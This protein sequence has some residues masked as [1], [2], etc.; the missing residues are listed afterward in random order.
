MAENTNITLENVFDIDIPKLALDSRFGSLV[1]ENAS[2]KFSQAQAWLKE[3]HDLE[4]KELL[5]ESDI[6]QVTNLTSR[7]VEHLEWIRNFDIGVVANPKQ[8][9]DGF[10]N[11]I[12]SF[13][14]DVYSQILMRILP[15]LREERRRKNP[16][17]EQLDEEVKKVVQ[18][19]SE[20]E[21]E[22]KSVREE[23]QKIRITNK[24]VGSA[25]GERATARL[26]AH[27]DNEVVR[28]ENISRKW[29]IAVILG[30][31]VIVGVLVW[32]GVI[33]T[34]YVNRILALPDIVSTN[35]LWSVI[36]SKLVILAAL[37]YGL[38]FIIKNYNVNSHLSAIN[39]HRAAVARTLEDFIAV[40]LQQEN[41]RISEILQNASEAMF[42]NM[43]IGYVSKTEKETGN[44]VL[45]VV[46][47]LIGI[48]NNG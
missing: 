40:E 11:R 10:N 22:L 12:D 25:R 8:E 26:A 24:E 3:T 32:L 41:P 36:I 33:T 23:T 28:Y 39:R 45:Q 47:D 17:Q 13:Y 6:Q 9:H 21:K 42:K 27:F 1:F 35:G 5:L 14:N 16:D 30:Y 18:I 31:T 46:N 7:L 38:S 37:W 2:K 19:R 34:S 44:P 20:L 29:F 15:F 4:Y 43:P 48:R